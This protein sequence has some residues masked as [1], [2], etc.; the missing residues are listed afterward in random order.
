MKSDKKFKR[1]CVACSQ[2]KKKNDLIKITKTKEGDIILNPTNFEHGRSVYICKSKECLD[3]AIGNKKL[4]KALKK[5][6][7]REILEQITIKN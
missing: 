1:R 3:I 6:I 2:Y 5:V 4:N 7:P